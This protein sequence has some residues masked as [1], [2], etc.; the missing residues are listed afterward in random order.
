MFINSGHYCLE[1]WERRIADH[2]VQ[3]RLSVAPGESHVSSI[4]AQL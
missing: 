2:L 1:A 3:E 4:R